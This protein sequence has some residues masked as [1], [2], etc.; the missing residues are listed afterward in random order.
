MKCLHIVIFFLL[1]FSIKITAV[2]ND[3]PTEEP[4]VETSRFFKI[5]LDAMIDY[6]EGDWEEPIDPEFFPDADSDGIRDEE[7][8]DHP[9]NDED[10][11]SS[12]RV[13]LNTFC[14]QSFNTNEEMNSTLPSSYI[15]C[16]G[17]AKMPTE[18]LTVSSLNSLSLTGD[19]RFNAISGMSNVVEI[20]N[21][22]ISAYPASN[23]KMS[24]LINL[25]N[26]SG[27]T[28]DTLNF[29]GITAT[30]VSGVTVKTY[31][32]LIFSYINNISSNMISGCCTQIRASRVDNYT[33]NSTGK[34][35]GLYVMHGAHLGNLT[36]TG[37]KEIEL[38]LFESGWNNGNWGHSS[39]LNNTNALSGLIMD[40]IAIFG[41]TEI[42]MDLSGL[43]TSLNRNR[44]ERLNV[45][46]KDFDFSV[47]NN[48]RSLGQFNVYATKINF[49][50]LENIS[51]IESGSINTYSESDWNSIPSEEYENFKRPLTILGKAS[52][53]SN[54]CQGLQNGNINLNFVYEDKNL[55]IP[56]NDI[57][58]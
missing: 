22:D 4:I 17:F 41:N 49:N 16:E 45:I 10:N 29:S 57:C 6:G 21:L 48:V 56:Y 13:F 3:E 47:L 27:K 42:P 36:M 34:L 35:S 54:F 11:Y 55:N 50:D 32:T 8:P 33:I 44:V 40:Y 20:D 19:N 15:S 14:G 18:E 1:F 28:F 2:E 9:S 30:N 39:T 43:S 38:V 53:S 12:W 26:L 46:S 51:L 5:H 31:L 58:E 7:D 24:Q 23:S 52:I 25:S 37:S